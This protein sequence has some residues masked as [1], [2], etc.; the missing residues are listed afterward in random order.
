[1][2]PAISLLPL[3]VAVTVFATVMR[4][5]PA[6]SVRAPLRTGAAATPMRRSVLA[7]MTATRRERARGRSVEDGLP[8]VVDLLAV[9]AASGANVR[10][11]VEATAN[12]HRGPASDALRKSLRAVAAG[13]RLSDALSA[14][15]AQS[16]AREAE[17]LRPLESVLVDSDH[18]GTPLAPSLQRLSDDLRIHR[19]RRAE[20][21]ARRIPVRLLLPLV[22]CVLPAF[23]LLT[24]V[25]LFAGIARD[26]L[27]DSPS[28]GLHHTKELP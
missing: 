27:A 9:A 5:R 14:V 7:A 26:A 11:A 12:R 3:L 16:T 17:A 6:A 10:R 23:A 25:P 20:T 2:G 15:V 28:L 4:L 13:D 24:V 19:Q 22:L 1:M 8:E 21:R 18:Y